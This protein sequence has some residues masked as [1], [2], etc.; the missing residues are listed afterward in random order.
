MSDPRLSATVTRPPV[1]PGFFHDNW[2]DETKDDVPPGA[3]VTHNW[4]NPQLL[5]DLLGS[6]S[7][8]PVA[9]LGATVTRPPVNPGFFRDNWS[10][11]ED[12]APLVPQ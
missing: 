2:Y 1:N 3:T 8:V 5:D 10:E 6:R 12:V 7:V 4:D 11:T 9:T